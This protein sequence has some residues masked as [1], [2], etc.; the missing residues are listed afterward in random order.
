MRSITAGALCVCGV[1][2]LNVESLRTRRLVDARRY[3]VRR[4]KSPFPIRPMHQIP[5]G[6][7]H[8][9]DKQLYKSI[10]YDRVLYSSY[11]WDINLVMVVLAPDDPQDSYTPFG[12]K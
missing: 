9:R 5:A 11:E 10:S 12:S 8:A 7:L 3:R 1:V 2:D 6:S 4:T